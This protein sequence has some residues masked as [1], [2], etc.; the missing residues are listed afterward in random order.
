LVE[1]FDGAEGFPAAEEA[2]S[3]HEAGGAAP[4]DQEAGEE[5]PPALAAGV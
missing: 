4:D 1:I 2:G 5:M 3:G